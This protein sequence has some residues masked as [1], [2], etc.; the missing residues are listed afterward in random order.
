MDNY[1][2]A[3]TVLQDHKAILLKIAEELLAREVLDADQVMRLAKG[4]ALQEPI[5]PS[6]PAAAPT[7]E[8]ARRET[9][10][11]PALVPQ[12]GKADR[13]GVRRLVIEPLSHW[14]IGPSGY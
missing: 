6:K 7:D 2:R 5:V 12:I 8:S 11:R 1:A 13:P 9:P 14:A 4:L 3:Q 10:E